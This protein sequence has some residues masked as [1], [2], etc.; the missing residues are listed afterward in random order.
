MEDSDDEAPDLELRKKIE[1]A[2]RANG[3]E[4]AV[5]DADDSDDSEEELMDDDQMMAIDEH[6]TEA[7]RS[8]AIEKN[9]DKGTSSAHPDV[10][11]L[12]L[13]LGQTSMLREKLL[14][15]RIAFLTWSR[16]S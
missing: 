10:I 4:A 15:S 1:E 12:L 9:G 8:R 11:L 16:Y 3:I 13:T 14:T 2:L 6:L 5:S 7:F